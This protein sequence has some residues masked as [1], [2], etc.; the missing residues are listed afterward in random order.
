MPAPNPKYLV[1]YRADYADEF[2][3]HGF[4]VMSDKGWS[5]NLNKLMKSDEPYELCFGTNE[6]I[7]YEK[8]SDMLKDLTA[9]PIS[10]FEA[11][12]IKNAFGQ[13]PFGIF[14]ELD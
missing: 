6:S 2:D 12:A 9:T 5:F 1:K 4:T 7:E 11:I 3:V 10:S 8:R 13:L 14:P